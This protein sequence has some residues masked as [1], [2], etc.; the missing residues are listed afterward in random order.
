M[1][2][3]VITRNV[4]LALMVVAGFMLASAGVSAFYKFDSAFSPLLLSG[5]LTLMVAILPMVFVHKGE[6]RITNKEGLLIL[7]LA[8]FLSCLFGLLP[9]AL[10]GGEF[11]LEN[12]WF[13]S[14]SGFTATGATCLTDIEALPRGLLFWR[15]ST[16]FLG[17]LGVVVFMM[18]ILPSAGTIK[19][20]MRHLEVSS[21][22][23]GDYN[24]R[25]NKIVGVV[26]TVYVSLMV[27][28]SL[29]FLVAGMPLFDSVCHAFSAVA[30]GGFSIRNTSIGAYDSRWIELI[31][32]FF[33]LMSSLHYGQIY[34]SI[35]GRNLGIFRNPVVKFFLASL[36]VGIVLVFAG[37]MISG[38]YTNPLMALWQATFNVVSLGSST[39]L[40]TVDTSVWPS[41]CIV[42]LL[43]FGI[44][45]GCSGSTTGGMKA[46]RIM[47]LARAVRAQIVR[48]FHPNAVVRINWGGQSAEV[49]MVNSVVAY[50]VLYF[51]IMLFCALIYSAC[52]MDLVDSF[53]GSCAC[54]GNVG[55][56][57][58]TIGS[59]ENYAAVPVVAKI[60]MGLEMIVGRLGIYAAFIVFA[61]KKR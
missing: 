8:W 7:F 46:D 14:A 26:L 57:F 18:I 23:A 27:A 24:Y 21:M 10:Y 45:C 2:H 40:A 49:G 13:E 61:L 47:L 37:L 30:T 32:M 54:V 33:M 22:S 4:A 19:L 35:S 36:G 51:V 41:F 43:Y 28:C 53:T 59:L 60:I 50:V 16:H 6:N 42:V 12:A 56:A 9:Y 34:A 38:T 15:Q 29:L 58:G 3:R 11:S 48:T 1:N 39:G 20:R 31:A 25:S 5:M 55:P 52:G 44:Q 17:G